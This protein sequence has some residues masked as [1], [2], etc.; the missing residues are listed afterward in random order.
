MEIQKINQSFYFSFF[1]RKV[2]NKRFDCMNK[3][4]LIVCE[5]CRARALGITGSQ[6]YF[7]CQL[8]YIN[9]L[10]IIKEIYYYLK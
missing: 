7:K 5:S 6:R 8:I 2:N 10:L 4:I 9:F 3:I 1:L